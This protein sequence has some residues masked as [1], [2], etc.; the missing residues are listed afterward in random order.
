MQRGYQGIVS[1]ATVD[2]TRLVDIHDAC[3]G[4]CVQDSYD[5]Y[6]NYAKKVNAKEAVAA[7]LWATWIVEKPS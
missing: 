5:S 6:S 2:S 7:S 3:A 4:L 1:K